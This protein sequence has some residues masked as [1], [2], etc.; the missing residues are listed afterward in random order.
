MTPNKQRMKSW[1]VITAPNGKEKAGGGGWGSGGEG[2]VLS[3]VSYHNPA[4]GGTTHTQSKLQLS[5]IRNLNACP[6]RN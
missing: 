6:E 1:G 5:V 3:K 2:G 4:Q